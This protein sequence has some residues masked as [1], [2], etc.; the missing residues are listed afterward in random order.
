M[1]SNS[2]DYI[3]VFQTSEL[4]TGNMSGVN[5]LFRCAV[6]DEVLYFLLYDFNTVYLSKQTFPEISKLNSLLNPSLEIENGNVGNLV[7][8]ILE[9][10]I[11]AEDNLTIYK[12]DGKI[13]FEIIINILKVRWEFDINTPDDG[14]LTQALFA[15]PML[16]ILLV[17]LGLIN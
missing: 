12:I 17:N 13:T 15:K 6:L 1:E 8:F 10:V 4:C 2:I 14:N 7:A 16:N 5:I 3:K 11:R 9:N